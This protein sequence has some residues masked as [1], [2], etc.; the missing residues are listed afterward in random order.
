MYDD[1]PKYEESIVYRANVISY[2]F[3]II[4]SLVF[5]LCLIQRQCPVWP[6]F[7][8][9]ATYFPT[10]LCSV[11]L[12][13]STV[14][15]CKTIFDKYKL[16]VVDSIKIDKSLFWGLLKYT[17]AITACMPLICYFGFIIGGFISMVI[18][19]Y[20][21]GSRKIVQIVCISIITVLVQYAAFWYGLKIILP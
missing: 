17:I 18:F 20:L 13:C 7:G 3:C 21:I 11:I 1:S 6:G 14:A 5:L 4:F 2:I 10:L 16:K 8:I 19:Q 15:L 9:P 12:I